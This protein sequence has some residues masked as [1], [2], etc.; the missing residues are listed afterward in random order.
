M[1]YEILLKLY[2]GIKLAVLPQTVNH[3]SRDAGITAIEYAIIGVAMSA[4]LFFIFSWSSEEPVGGVDFLRYLVYAWKLM[5]VKITSV[6]HI[7]K[8]LA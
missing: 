5:E 3:F 8:K 1:L 7:L 2:I 6:Q 4:G